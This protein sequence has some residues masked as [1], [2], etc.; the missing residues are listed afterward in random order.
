MNTRK[1]MN[2]FI[3]LCSLLFILPA[4][5]SIFKKTSPTHT[6]VAYPE[7]PSER[8]N[9]PFYDVFGQRY[10]VR[11]SSEGYYSEGV[12][13]W[14]GPDF[15]GKSTSSGEIYNMYGMTAAHKELPIPCYV[16]VTNLE[17]GLSIIVRVNDRGPFHTGRI[18]DL[19]YTAAEKLGIIAKGTANVAVASL[20]PFQSLSGATGSVVHQ[21]AKKLY[22]QLGAFGQEVN[23]KAYA[24]DL[25][26]VIPKPVNIFRSQQAF[27][28][29]YRV[30]IGPFTST[31]EAE[32]A[33][34]M[35]AQAGMN[36]GIFVHL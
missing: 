16:K 13:S 6:R 10:Y 12:A 9:P 18:I 2:A 8:G 36:K 24:R 20:P 7:L 35:L 33:N 27:G 34:L 14:Y 17:N 22:L 19:S 21:I 30:K 3:L 15:H 23:A 32:E 11:D 5:A 4:K 28:M 26:K 1:K 29:I 31:Q 25:S